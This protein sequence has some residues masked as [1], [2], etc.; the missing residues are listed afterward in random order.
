MDVDGN[1]RGR[2]LKIHRDAS[3]TNYTVFSLWDTYRACHPLMTIIDQKRTLDYIKT[4]L[5][6]Y[7]QGGLLPVWELAGNETFCMIGYHSVPVIVDAYMKGIRDFD[8]E[9]AFEAMRKSAFREGN[10]GLKALDQHGYISTEDESES[11]SKTLEYAYDD[12]CIAEFA[13]SIGKDDQ[14]KYFIKR[15]QNYKNVFDNSTGPMVA[16]LI[17][18]T[19][20]KL[21]SII[22][23]QIR[24]NTVFQPCRI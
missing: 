14:Y 21:I 7:D 22:L 8:T 15:G 18:S 19:L 4:F 2:D 6:Q 3:F 1:Y 9:K 10:T 11:V 23:K 20:L 5:T 12:W 24:G 17:H 13:K 16:G